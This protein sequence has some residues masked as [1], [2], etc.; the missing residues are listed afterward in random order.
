MQREI[1]TLSIR[2]SEMEFSFLCRCIKDDF[3][4]YYQLCMEDPYQD[5]AQ[6]LDRMS[7]DLILMEKALACVRSESTEFT[8]SQTIAEFK[9]KIAEA[10]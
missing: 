2:L 7:E 9:R 8:I 4:Y 5:N 10:C 1:G 3:E 6:S